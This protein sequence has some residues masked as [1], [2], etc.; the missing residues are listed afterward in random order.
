[1]QVHDGHDQ[2]HI[3]TFP[4]EHP[5]RK[6]LGQTSPHIEFDDREETRVKKDAVG[7]ILYGGKETPAEVRLLG[8]VVRR[9]IKH[10]GIRVRMELDSS[11]LSDA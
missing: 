3:G 4:E 10:L 9:G 6:R 11:H 7:G 5:K 1:M 8:L 2:D